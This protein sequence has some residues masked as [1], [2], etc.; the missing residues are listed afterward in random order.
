MDTTTDPIDQPV[1]DKRSWRG[2]ASSR[3][4]MA[5]GAVAA[6]LALGGAGFGVGYAVGGDAAST[7]VARQDQTT[8]GDWG[9]PGFR[10]GPGGDMGGQPGV[11]PG[12]DMGGTTGQAPDLDGDGQPDTGTDPDSGSDTDSS[13]QLS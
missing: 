5:A 11:P 4:A 12:G 1:T 9:D 2:L 8:D 7:D 10:G 13:T 3:K 6:G